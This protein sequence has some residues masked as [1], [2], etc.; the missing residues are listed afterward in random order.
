MHTV[1]NSHSHDVHLHVGVDKDGHRG[2]NR[3]TLRSLTTNCA[4]ELQVLN[5]ALRALETKELHQLNLE[6][7]LLLLTHLCRA[8]YDTK[9]VD[10]F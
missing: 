8:C 9:C 5:E 7:K 3:D 1:P 6:H 4:H 10:L 2:P